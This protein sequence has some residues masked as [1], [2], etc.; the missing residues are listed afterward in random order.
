MLSCPISRDYE[1]KT[2][3]RW[4]RRALDLMLTAKNPVLRGCDGSPRRKSEA[5][6]YVGA[7]GPNLPPGAEFGVIPNLQ[8]FVSNISSVAADFIQYVELLDATGR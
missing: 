6:K 2:L 8:M 5:L 7:L 4:N 1:T 3:H